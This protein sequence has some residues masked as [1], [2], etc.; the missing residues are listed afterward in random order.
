MLFTFIFAR[1]FRLRRTRAEQFASIVSVIL[2]LLLGFLVFLFALKVPCEGGEGM[3]R[4]SAVD[5]IY[6]TI[7]TIST[8]GYGDISPIENVALRTFTVFYIMLGCGY[9]FVVLAQIFEARL[10]A[11]TTSIKRCVDVFDN[12]S[13]HVDSTGDGIADMIVPGRQLGLSGKEV[14]L[15][16]DGQADFI[17]PPSAF[18]YWM[19]EL[20]P[21]LMLL[22]AFQF[23][24]AGVFAAILPEVDYGTALYHCFIT[25]TTV[26][27][28][29]VP[30]ANWQ[31]RAFASF[32][33]MVSVSWLAAVLGSIDTLRAV[34]AAQMQRAALLIDPPDRDDIMSLDYDKKGVDE[35]EFVVG[36]LINLG[37][38]LCGEPLKWEDVRPFRLQFERFDVSKTGRLSSDDLEEYVKEQETRQRRREERMAGLREERLELQEQQKQARAERVES[39]RA[40]NKNGRMSSFLTRLHGTSK[41]RIAPQPVV[42]PI[43]DAAPSAPVRVDP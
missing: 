10:R 31:S 29:D 37:V 8:V 22:L 1:I 35:V 30:M 39:K 36:M 13:S 7:V 9:V 38:E 43:A 17:L 5:A 16:G 23:L 28:G 26:G 25:A 19:Q 32:H 41:K 6:F 18:V 20:L 42:A 2:A 40:K 33:I 15:S 12:T 27:Y 3:C 34:R 21:G 24:S 11:L 14:D 4:L